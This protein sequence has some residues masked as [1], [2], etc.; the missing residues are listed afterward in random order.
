MKFASVD[1]NDFLSRIMKSGHDEEVY[2]ILCNEYHQP[3]DARLALKEYKSSSTSK[4]KDL[5][6][7]LAKNC[8]DGVRKYHGY[9]GEQVILEALLSADLPNKWVHHIL[10]GVENEEETYSLVQKFLSKEYATAE[11]KN[12]SRSKSNIARLADFTVVKRGTFS[13]QIISVDVKSNE[14]AFDYFL[15]QADDFSRFSDEIYLV[16]TPELVLK[17]GKKKSG[18]ANSAEKAFTST[19]KKHGVGLYVLDFSSQVI[20]KVMAANEN[21]A[22]KHLKD[23]VLSELGLRQR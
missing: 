15:N 6:L 3:A 19:L 9:S 17:E 14:S 13:T 16:A 5:M 12:T 20:H 4:R 10:G 8:T 18:G 22:D 21:K 11:V 7:G 23:K 2:K 1:F